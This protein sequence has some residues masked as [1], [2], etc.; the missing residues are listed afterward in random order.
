ML[1]ELRG[2]EAIREQRYSVKTHGESRNP[3]R[4]R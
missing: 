1:M 3:E 2:I 4:K